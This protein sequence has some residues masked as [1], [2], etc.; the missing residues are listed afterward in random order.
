M[1]KVKWNQ[2]NQ[3]DGIIRCENLG[4][5]RFTWPGQDESFICESH[6]GKLRAVAAAM[7][8]PLQIIPLED[9]ELEDFEDA[10]P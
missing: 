7:G 9:W 4:L 1:S 5:Y 10:K 6:V 2:C 3:R 8:L